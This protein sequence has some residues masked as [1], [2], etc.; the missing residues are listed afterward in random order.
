MLVSLGIVVAIV[1][2]FLAG[3]LV[4]LMYGPAYAA[5]SAPLRILIWSGVAVSFGCAWS[6]WMILEGRAKMLFYF[7]LT[8]AIVNILLNLILIP[9]LG[10]IGSALATLISYWIVITIVAA[11]VATQRRGLVMLGKSI[12]S[13]PTL[14]RAVTM[15]NSSYRELKLNL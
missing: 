14:I 12:I 7:Q 4:R 11:V 15:K 5:S 10:I 9:R 3:P 13:F 8:G 6:N 2:T 1:T